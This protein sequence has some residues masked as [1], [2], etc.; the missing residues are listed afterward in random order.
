MRL[1][2]YQEDAIANVEKALSRVR[3]TLVQLPTGCGKTVV[4]NDLASRYAQSM[5]RTLI[6]AHREELIFQAATALE[7]A[8]GIKAAIEKAERAEAHEIVPSLL[9]AGAPGVGP[10]GKPLVV[11]GSV[12]SMVRR[13]DR[14]RPD[15]FDLVVIDEC[16]PAGTP[17]YTTRFND[18]PIETISVGDEVFSWSHVLGRKVIGRVTRVFERKPSGR[19]TRVEFAGGYSM[20]C[21]PE[22]PFW[23]QNR[24]K[25]EPAIGLRPGDVLMDQWDGTIEVA[26]VVP[27]AED[28]ET[29]YN[30]EVTRT[31][32]GD[33]SWLR[34]NFPEIASLDAI[35]R[36]ERFT[37]EQ[38]HNYFAGGVLVH[39]CHHAPAKT[40]RDIIDHFAP[41]KVLGVSATPERSDQVALG[42]IFDDVAYRYEI[43]DGIE[44]GWLV[45]IHQQV[46]QTQH[47]DLSKV[48]TTAGD[49]NLGDL[50]AA[51]TQ[52][53]LLH[54]I[55]GPAVELSGDRQGIVFAVTV[56]HAYLLAE[57]MR[58]QIAD[59][60]RKLGRGTPPQN[61]VVALDGTTDV[62]ER[63]ETI[64][65]F[66]RGE[67]QFLLNCSLFVEGT[68]LPSVGV[69]VMAAPTKSRARYTQMIG[70]GTRPLPGIVDA[71]PG[72]DESP[73]R[74]SAIALSPKT[75]VL[76]IDFTENS[77]KHKLISAADLLAGKYSE[78]ELAMAKAMLARH[79]VKDILEALRRARAKI[80]EMEE[81]RAQAR[82]GYA[83]TTIDPFDPLDILDG[84]KQ[85]GGGPTVSEKQ[86]RVL[87]EYGVEN[88]ESL[89]AVQAAGL[90]K[91]V[92]ERKAAGLAD[93]NQVRVLMRRGGIRADR[94]VGLT[95]LDAAGYIAKLAKNGWRRPPSWDI[96]FGAPE[97][98]K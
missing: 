79:E 46:V 54:E 4:F 5:R 80:K 78:P 94:A 27:D 33:L 24:G 21:T 25:Y 8:T 96:K 89:D 31:P 43:V 53:D 91:T 40:Y 73:L 71:H 61:I 47:L 84:S 59:R 35:I 17:I 29:V 57:A 11:V 74:R 67:I 48:R 97:S 2:Y 69:V 1:R 95:S 92:A 72:R 23:V 16:F 3:S 90:L 44:D 50:E 98:T 38:P 6:L 42:S 52:T 60:W 87:K 82:K 51:M 77:G 12:Q 13:L 81:M 45:P 10:D 83:A 20:A 37:E 58:E 62:D 34:T 15:H 75:H 64:E 14:F 22:H 39:N 88:V 70:R 85:G 30:L 93:F 9:E 55:A 63:R 18:Q 68:D 86:R 76:V 32:R 36:L 66:R 26:S 7:R 49:L 65:A 56:E 41:A 28:A 19:L